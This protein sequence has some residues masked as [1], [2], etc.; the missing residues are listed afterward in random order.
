MLI[1]VVVVVVI[2]VLKVPEVVVVAIVHWT[3]GG[4]GELVCAGNMSRSYM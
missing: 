4:D 3:D 1:I 2:L